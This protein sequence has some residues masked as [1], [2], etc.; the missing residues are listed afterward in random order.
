MVILVLFAF[1]PPVSS[2][3]SSSMPMWHVSKLSSLRFA[4]YVPFNFYTHIYDRAILDCSPVKSQSGQALLSCDSLTIDDMRRL[5][6]LASRCQSHSLLSHCNPGHSVNSTNPE[7]NFWKL[8]QLHSWLLQ[9]DTVLSDTSVSGWDAKP[10]RGT[11]A[12]PTASHTGICVTDSP[13]WGRPCCSAWSSRRSWTAG[14]CCWIQ[15]VPLDRPT[16]P[17]QQRDSD[18]FREAFFFITS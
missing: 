17:I 7:L 13:V 15:C 2:Q 10:L 3:Y 9:C 14:L 6:L 1:I 5:Y 18:T 11:L 8:L 12:S 16:L 4:V